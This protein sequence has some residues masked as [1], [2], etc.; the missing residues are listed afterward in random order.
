MHNK[1]WGITAGLLAV[2]VLLAAC[3]PITPVPPGTPAPVEEGGEAASVPLEGTQWGGTGYASAQGNM[4]TP[5]GSQPTAIFQDG[6]VSGTTGCNNYFGTFV[7]DGNNLTVS[8]MGSTMMACEEPLMSQEADFLAALSRAATYAINGDTLEISDASGNVVLTFAVIEPSA[9]TGTTW[10]VTGYNNGNEAVVSVVIGTELTAIFGEDGSLSGSAGCNNMAGSYTTQDN[11]IQIGPIATTRMM[12]VEPEGVMEQEA[13]YTAALMSA[14]TYSVRGDQLEMRTADDAMAVLFVAQEAME[15]AEGAE[16]VE[17]GTSEDTV[18]NT[19]ASNPV[20]V[21]DPLAPEVLGNM[22]YQVETFPTGAVTLVD[23]SYTEAIPDSSTT[24]GAVLIPEFTAY[25][26][27]N[28]VPTAAVIVAANGGGSGTFYYLEVVQVQDGAPVNVASTLLGDRVVVNS[29]S[30]END[31]IYV[32]LVTQGPED[33]A[34]CP[35][36]ETV[37]AYQLLGDQLVALPD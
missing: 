18:S 31:T 35:T 14:A 15:P 5:Q 8:D 27:L 2:V 24:M 34:C 22:S 29:V 1:F 25:G 33:P 12:C 21:S 3:V 36:V 28:G 4:M 19:T 6:S 11:T 20:A 9:L 23:G 10:V 7:T 13:Q 17:S 32:D 26:E 16:A 37:A 30:I